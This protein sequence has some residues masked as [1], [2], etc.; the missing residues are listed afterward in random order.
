MEHTLPDLSYRFDALEPFIDART[1]EIHYSKHHQ[2][3]ITNLNAALKG[4]DQLAALTVEQ[5]VSR[6]NEVPENIRTVVRNHGGG[7]ANHSF[8]WQVLKKDTEPGGPILEAIG[9]QFGSF[10]SFQN[11]FS[12]AALKQ[13]GSG[14]AWLVVSGGKLEIVSTANQ[15]SPLTSGKKPVLGIDV[16]EHAYYLLY[17]NRRADYIEAFFKVINWPKVNEHYTAAFSKPL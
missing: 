7:H 8:F 12:T 13:F 14:W 2:A 11:A 4:Y 5:L 3:Y 9:K 10:E 15:D 6:L 17:Q 16:W 1:M